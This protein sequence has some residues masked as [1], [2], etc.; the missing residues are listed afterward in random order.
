MHALLSAF[1]KSVTMFRPRP[2]V[3]ISGETVLRAFIVFRY[4]S[5]LLLLVHCSQYMPLYNISLFS[6][7]LGGLNGSDHLSRPVYC[8]DI[9]TP[10]PQAILHGCHVNQ[11]QASHVLCGSRLTAYSVATCRRCGVSSKCGPIDADAGLRL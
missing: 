10:L 8:C 3:L 5:F 7:I 4:V 2:P 1:N 9:K 6:L 11:A